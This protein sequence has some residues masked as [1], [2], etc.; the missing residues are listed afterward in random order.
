TDIWLNSLEYRVL[1]ED[2][3]KVVVVSDARFR[4]ELDL[5]K[6]MGGKVVWVQRGE[7]PEWYDIAVDANNG[8]AVSRKIMTTKY[9]SVHESEWNW[10]GYPVDHI[11]DNNGSFNQLQEAVNDIEMDLIVEKTSSLRLV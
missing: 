1:K 7:L 4:N 11:V 5:I 2:P 9:A 3:D 8:N 10:C 6:S